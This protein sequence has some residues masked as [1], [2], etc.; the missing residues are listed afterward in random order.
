MNVISSSQRQQQQRQQQ[1]QL[2]EVDISLIMKESESPMTQRN[3]RKSFG[4]WQRVMK[5][6]N[7]SLGSTMTA[8][9]SMLGS[10][11][12][13][14]D[15]DEEDSLCMWDDDYYY[16]TTTDDDDELDQTIGG[17]S[18][19]R[20]R[21]SSLSLPQH[22][23]HLDESMDLTDLQFLPRQLQR[24]EKPLVGRYNGVDEES[25]HASYD[26]GEALGEGAFGSVHKCY[27][28]NGSEDA[29]AVKSVPMDKYN[30]EEIE[31]LDELKEC[32][33][34][35]QL[36]DVF[37]ESDE[38]FIV[39]EEIQGGE[40]LERIA[41][42][43]CYSEEEAKVLFKTLL[44]TVL[45]CHQRGIAHCDIKPENILLQSQDDDTT[46]K[47]VDFGLAKRFRHD[48]EDGTIERIFDMHGSA[49]YAAPE[50]FNRPEDDT[51]IGYD[52]RCD[53]WSCGVVLYV[54]LGGYA[55]FEA[56]TSD[57]MIKVVG[58]GKFKFHKRYW[59]HVSRDAKLLI[60]KMMQ[61]KPD[62]RCTLEEALA[63]PWFDTN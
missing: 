23:S 35:V 30:H 40:L 1:Q 34:I 39:M 19:K 28:A 25:F 5:K 15:F 6:A 54:L 4:C 61:V 56:D 27:P 48:D 49:E 41:E 9:T 31:I 37:H 17:S 24:Q 33:T 50:V 51:E 47:L 2:Q 43:E 26:L 60:A 57:E 58:K 12:G 46:M 16:G 29:Y 38:S 13:E 62:K 10:L 7:A 63:S 20:H 52:E 44:E 32:P 42:K 53:I 18:S 8:A 55:P 3:S 21:N 36:K 22:H 59:K 14:F 45:Y 11:D